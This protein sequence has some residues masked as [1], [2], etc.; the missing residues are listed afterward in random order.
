[1]SWLYKNVLKPI[2]SIFSSS[3]F[4]SLGSILM[5]TIKNIGE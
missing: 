5:P 1:M 2:G 4:K 3:N